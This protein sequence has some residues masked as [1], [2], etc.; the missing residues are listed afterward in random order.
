M[1]NGKYKDAEGRMKDLKA[2]AGD[3]Q[4]GAEERPSGA[5]PLNSQNYEDDQTGIFNQFTDKNNAAAFRAMEG[6]SFYLI[7]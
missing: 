4:D 1:T 3:W 7:C 5:K 6:E 2:N